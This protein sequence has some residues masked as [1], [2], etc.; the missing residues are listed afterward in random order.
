MQMTIEIVLVNKILSY[1]IMSY[2]I[3]SKFEKQIKIINFKGNKCL[4][5]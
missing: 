3:M 1:K 2:K 4:E 5:V